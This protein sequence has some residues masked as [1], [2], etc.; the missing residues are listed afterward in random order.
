M[1]YHVKC[2]FTFMVTV[3]HVF[4]EF[5]RVN[6]KIK[7]YEKASGICDAYRSRFSWFPLL[8]FTLLMTL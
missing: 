3:W 8:R 1:Q 6:L 2:I 5:S 7:L 4:G